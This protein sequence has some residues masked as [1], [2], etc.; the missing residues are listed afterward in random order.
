M[1]KDRHP[2]PKLHAPSI[3]Q[4]ERGYAIK[5]ISNG[6]VGYEFIDKFQLELAKV[7]GV[8]HAIAMSSGT[9]AL[10]IALL[11]VGVDRDTDVILPSLT[12]AA[13]ANAVD[14][15]GAM[16]H[17]IDCPFL[18]TAEH[19]EQYYSTTMHNIRATA[20]IAVD[21]LGDR[22]DTKEL[23]RIA[24]MRGLP[25]IEDAAEAMGNFHGMNGASAAILSFNCNKLVT[26]GGGGALLTDDDDIAEW[27]L[28]MS[29]T[30]RTDHPWLVGHDCVAFNYRLSNIQAAIGLAQ[31]ERLEEMKE[32]KRA[33][34]EHYRQAFM[35]IDNVEFFGLPWLNAI[36]VANRDEVLATLQKDG[37]GA[38]AL[39]TP[40][41]RL[42]HFSH[43]PRSSDEMP[44]CEA[45][46]GA[47]L[48]LPSGPD[49]A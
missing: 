22:V 27:A 38:R 1:P 23:A 33:L 2:N 35:E 21:L 16:P 45:T 26:M 6:L 43:M 28:K 19:I 5:A 39:F 8:K 18:V 10:H 4:F 14:Y 9:A 15:C 37:L 49:L 24:N 25:L 36:A 47:F 11:C 7:C 44:L 34:Q 3:G 46:W 41:H 32:A 29:A 42:P 20:I 17:F 48:T 30:A 13:T 40:L 12:F 31:L